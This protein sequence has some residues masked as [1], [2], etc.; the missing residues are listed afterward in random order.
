MRKTILST[1]VLVMT[2]TSAH[3]I[4]RYQ[5]TSLSCSAIQANIAREGA[6]ILRY[7]SERNPS[8]TLYDRYVKHGG[9]CSSGE[10]LKLEE[11]P[12][13]DTRQCLVY[14][15]FQRNSTPGR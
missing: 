11:V 6:V 15:C 9:F 1:L 12:A 5:S 8:L 7:K 13:R 14:R 4:S 10:Y 2:A 3:A